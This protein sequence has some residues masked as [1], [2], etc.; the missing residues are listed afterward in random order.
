MM[1]LFAKKKVVSAQT[2]AKLNPVQLTEEQ[3]D[4]VSGGSLFAPV[5]ILPGFPNS[6]TQ[7]TS[8]GVGHHSGNSLFS[9][10][11]PAGI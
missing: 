3:L 1:K 4:Q 2:E 11:H 6:G 5:G 10:F 8:K 9:N 7:G